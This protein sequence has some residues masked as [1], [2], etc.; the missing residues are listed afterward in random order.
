MIISLYR[1]TEVRVLPDTCAMAGTTGGPADPKPDPGDINERLADIAAELADEATFKEPSAAERARTPAAKPTARRDGPLR[2]RRN[3]RIAA[4]LRRPVQ[5]AS[6]SRQP[7][8]D[9]RGRE[10]ARRSR[11]AV[12]IL[13]AVIVA[14]VLLAASFG[15]R[16]LHNSSRSALPLPTQATSTPAL[17]FTSADPFADSTA[18]GYADGA[19][20]IHVPT[21]RAHSPFTAAQ[22]GSALRTV[23]QLLVAA[24][25]NPATLHG[26]KPTAF[27]AL[28]IPKQRSMFYRDLKAGPGHADTT[29][30]WLTSFAPGTDLVGSVIKVHGL[31]MTV[32]VTAYRGATALKIH[33]NYLFVYPV[34][35]H[36]DPFSRIRVITRTEASVLFYQWDDPGGK[37]EPWLLDITTSNAAAQCGTTD[38]FVYPDFPGTGPGKAR[39][40][41]P[42]I[43]PYNLHAPQPKSCRPITGT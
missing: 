37:L 36:G 22:V 4:K 25:L 7:R 12:S 9:R 33:V 13:V 28:L 30:A 19:A 15:L 11:P 23:R 21:A 16:K 27:A 1:Y 3:K 32:S 38:G 40:H 43:H 18:E 17:P 34:E 5:S 42:R 8:R 39:P 31:P 41:G 6:G 2:R 14:A 10:P 26:G 29:R 20:G 24:Y 35:Q